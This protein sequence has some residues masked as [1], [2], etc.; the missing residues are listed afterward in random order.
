VSGATAPGFSTPKVK[1]P[2]TNEYVDLVPGMTLPPGTVVDLSGGGG[3]QLTNSD[4]Q[5][6]TFYG[7]DA[8]ASQIVISGELFADRLSSGVKAARPPVENIVLTGGNFAACKTKGLHTKTPPPVRKLWGK[9][10]GHY[11]TKGRFAAATVLG[12]W[13]ATVDRCDGTLIIVKQGVV[14]VRDL[15]TKK[16]HT[17]TAGHSYLAKTPQQQK[18]KARGKK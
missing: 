9:G 5:T 2:G 13:W 3:I 16:N 1:L 11:R 18:K 14:V 6:M 15:V 17:V 8:S 4:G 7:E 10:K 12:T